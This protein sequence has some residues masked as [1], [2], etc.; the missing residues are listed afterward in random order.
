MQVTFAGENSIISIG[1][2]SLLVDVL[3]AP[4]PAY[5]VNDITGCAHN[6][7]GVDPT[8]EQWEK[9]ANVVEKR[10]LFPFFDVA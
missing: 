3:H 7:T 9:I 10:N 2:D 6:P 5:D 4:V 8:K 1:D